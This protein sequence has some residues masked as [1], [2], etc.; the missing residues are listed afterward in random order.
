MEFN[1]PNLAKFDYSGEAIPITLSESMKIIQATV[2]LMGYDDTL[3]HVL[4]EL[5]KTLSHVETLFVRTCI[6]TE[7]FGFSRCLVK[8]NH[9]IKLEVTVS[10]L[11]D[12]RN[13]NGILR[14]AN[15]L[16]VAPHLQRLELNML[17]HVSGFLHDVPEAY[18]HVQP[19]THHH[20]EHVEVSGFIG[21]N[22][23]VELVL[24][25][26]DNAVALRGM[27]IEPR[28]TAYDRVFGYWA[29]LDTDIRRGRECA[30]E[31]FLPEDYPDVQMEIF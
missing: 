29:G 9:L 24:Y 23:Q 11:G 13:Q 20:L 15:L 10:I 5:P 17:P 21:V 31:N 16:E 2:S 26:L 4:T 30:L 27:S 22:G 7:V 3:E 6:N 25:I 8:Y 18:W 14:L 1:A 19:C 12:S 28:V